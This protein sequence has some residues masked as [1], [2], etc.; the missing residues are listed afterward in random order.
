MLKG[1]LCYFAERNPQSVS[2]FFGKRYYDILCFMYMTAVNI[3]AIPYLY[4]KGEKMA[5][6]TVQ[7]GLV[8]H[9]HIRDICIFLRGKRSSEE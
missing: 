2:G 9:C 4:V 3:T 5:D 1:I 8:F 7:Y 6:V